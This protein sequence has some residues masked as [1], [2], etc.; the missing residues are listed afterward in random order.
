MKSTIDNYFNKPQKALKIL[1][2]FS[3][4]IENIVQAIVSC[5][6]TKNT[7]CWW[8]ADRQLTQIILLEN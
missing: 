8:T 3:N 1:N 5:Q 2:D 6:K 7:S 4:D